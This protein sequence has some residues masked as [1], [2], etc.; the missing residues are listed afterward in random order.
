MPEE[1]IATLLAQ[2]TAQQALIAGLQ[3]RIAELERRLGLNSGDSGKLPSS[4]GLTKKPARVSSLRELQALVE[5][6]KEDWARKM[7]RLLRRACH[8]TNLAREQGMPLSSRLI[9]LFERCYDT[10]LAEGLVFHEAQ[11]AL[12]RAAGKGKG[13]GRQPRRVGHNLLSRLSGRKPDVLRFRSDPGVPFTNNLAER[14]G[15]MLEPRSGSRLRQK[16][17]GGF[18]SESGAADFGVIRSLLSTAKKQGRDMLQTLTAN[19]NRLIADL[20]VG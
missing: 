9:A 6:E 7:Q 13:R 11:P 15:G 16:I 3:A 19:Q 20:R 10:I 4:D 12:L 5:I 14:D 17:S 2:N 18:R 1:V 8:A